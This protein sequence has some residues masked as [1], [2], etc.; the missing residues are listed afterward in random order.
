MCLLTGEDLPVL[1]Q[2]LPDYFP[3]DLYADAEQL[4]DG[5]VGVIEAVQQH[6]RHLTLLLPY[7]P[8]K[9][10]KSAMKSMFC[11]KRVLE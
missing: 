8:E 3:H 5:G 4:G 1:H 6:L 2:V 9:I 7:Q 10:R 11:F